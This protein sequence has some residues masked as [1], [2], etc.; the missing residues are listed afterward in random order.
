MLKKIIFLVLLLSTGLTVFACISSSL[1]TN[2]PEDVVKEYWSY[3]LKGKLEKAEDL[4]CFE[5]AC[6]TSPTKVSTSPPSTHEKTIN[7]C[8]DADEIAEQGLIVTGISGVETSKSRAQVIVDVEDSK[9]VKS[10]Y[11]NCLNRNEY[12]NW[13]ITRV[14]M[15]STFY[16]PDV[17]DDCAV[18]SENKLTDNP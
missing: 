3:V 17:S 16:V 10:Q 12:G 4:V 1:L 11:I 13:K 7:N 8:C 15:L 18:R 5:F 9:K 14:K 2:K 6:G